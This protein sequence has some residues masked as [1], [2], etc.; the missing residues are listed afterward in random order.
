VLGEFLGLVRET[1]PRCIFHFASMLT[2]PAES[3]HHMAFRVNVV[4]AQNLLEAARL[5]EVERVL[6]VS[7]N[8]IYAR[9]LPEVIDDYSP[10]RPNTFYGCAKV[11]AEDLGRWYRDRF[12]L[13][14]RTVRYPMIVVPGDRAR[15]HWVPPMIEDAVAG[16]P[17][18]CVEGYA[19]WSVH[20]IT[21]GD[22]ARAAVEL[23]AA[24]AAAIR[25]RCYTVLGVSQPVLAEE[26]AE[27]LSA[28]YPGFT[29][30]FV[31][32]S[33]PRKP[34]QISDRYAREEWG[35]KP[36]AATVDAII[37]DIETRLRSAAAA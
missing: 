16:R 27:A 8:G 23:A 7:S 10:Q 15:Y 32:G 36:Q 9:D 1:R 13:D 21:V 31:R 37:S 6:Y 18:R 19:G 34:R 3:R 28:R 25:T 20:M 26:V 22:A 5:G 4:G 14:F 35:W 24:P 29:V 12:G 33:Q 11:L 17:H 2:G 30:E